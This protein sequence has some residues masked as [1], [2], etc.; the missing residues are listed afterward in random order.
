MSD[1]SKDGK[2]PLVSINEIV[3]IY[4]VD[5]IG[6]LLSVDDI[7]GIVSPDMLHHLFDGSGRP[8]WLGS[9]DMLHHTF[10]ILYK[11]AQRPPNVHDS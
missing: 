10:T 4:S 11:N 2:K 7:D 3:G 6:G 9:A 5:D 8:T 1:S